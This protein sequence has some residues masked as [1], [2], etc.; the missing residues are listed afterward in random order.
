MPNDKKNNTKNDD[1][2][3][4]LNSDDTILDTQEETAKEEA[5]EE[6][7]DDVKE[8]LGLEEDPKAKKDAL[9]APVEDLD[10]ISEDVKDALNEI[11]NLM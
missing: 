9:K 4:N 3:M 6:L 1:Q 11:D 8:A 2:V 10:Y 7:S 5:I